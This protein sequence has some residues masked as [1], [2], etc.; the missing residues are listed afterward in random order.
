M[1]P[2]HLALVGLVVVSIVIAV[3]GFRVMFRRSELDEAIDAATSLALRD[4][5]E[6]LE[7]NRGDRGK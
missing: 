1:D 4:L 7:R 6:W 3:V 5:R 2:T